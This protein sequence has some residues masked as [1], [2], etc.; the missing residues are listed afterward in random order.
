M[1]KNIVLAAIVLFTVASCSSGS[2]PEEKKGPSAK[3]VVDKYVETVTTAKPKAE[4]A[5]KATEERAEEQKK[6]LEQMDK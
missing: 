3:E 2:K 1:D 5:I 4:A 6:M